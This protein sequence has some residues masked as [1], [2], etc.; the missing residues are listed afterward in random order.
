MTSW[1][2]R[3]SMGR[4]TLRSRRYIRLRR[5][6]RH[7]RIRRDL[8]M[9]ARY[10]L[11]RMEWSDCL[12]LCA[13]STASPPKREPAKTKAELRKMLAAAVRN[14]QPEPKRPSKAKKDR[15]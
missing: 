9:A 12:G 5:Y 8:R 6:G 3:Y 13:T 15:D 10:L 1:F 7:S 14:T 2:L 4:Y 11:R